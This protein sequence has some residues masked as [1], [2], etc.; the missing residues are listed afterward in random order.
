MLAEF[1]LEGHASLLPPDTQ[2]TI[3]LSYVRLREIVARADLLVNISG[4]L[5]DE[6]F[7]RIPVRAWLD[8]DP[9][10]NQ[11]WQ[12]QG[13][14][15]RMAGHT[16]FV[17]IG[18]AIG[19]PGCRV[20]TCGFSWIPTPQP[21]V[22]SQ[23]PVAE[24]LVYDAFTTV[25]NWR[26]YGPI[27]ADGVFYGQKAHS[28][29]QFFSLP[30]Q[31]G[32][33]FLLAMS[34]HPDEHADL[35]ALDR[36]GWRLIEPGRV[37]G[38][39]RAY[40]DF[41]RGSLAELGIAKSGYVAANCGW[42][43][44]RSLCYLASG[45][46]VV[47]QETGFSRFLPTGAGLLAFRT[48]DE[49]AE[50]V[51]CI[52][53]DYARHAR[54]ARGLAEEHF[55]SSRGTRAAPEPTGSGPMSGSPAGT[56][57]LTAALQ[58]A[59]APASPI[60]AIRRRPFD[61]RSS[62]PLE[63]IELSFADGRRQTLI[64]K[65]LA[66]DA[67]PE[68]RQIKP[69]FLF[70]PRREIDV[71]R[72]ILPP[73]RLDTARCY[74]AVSDRRRRRY[75]LFLEKVA[76]IEF[77]QAG[78][79]ETWCDAARWLARLHAHFAGADLAALTN[80]CHL[81]TLDA[82]LFRQFLQRACRFVSQSRE[83]AATTRLQRLADRYEPVLGALS[84]LPRTFIHGEFY[85][86]NVLVNPTAQP[87]RICP[88]D[89]E[90]AAIGP[91][92]VDLA[93]LVVGKW[94]APQQETIAMAY[95]A[96]LSPKHPLAGDSQEFPAGLNCCRRQLAVQWLGW[97][98]DWL[99][100][101]AHAPRLAGRGVPHGGRTGSVDLRSIPPVLGR[102]Q[103]KEMMRYVSNERRSGE[104]Q[105]IAE[106]RLHVSRA[107]RGDCHYWHPGRANCAG[108]ASGAGS[109]PQIPVCQQPQTMGLGCCAT[110]RGAPDLSHRW[111][112][113]AV[114]RRARTRL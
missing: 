43:S 47:A 39:P 10:F 107:S 46:P 19:Q 54:A 106:P 11:L 25:G 114:G 88:V 78:D 31:T 91:G 45:R 2:D 93:A 28:L 34:I 35:E 76:A 71:Y 42:F 17:T 87:L 8:L 7:R 14:D 68:T 113:V 74:G 6:A 80:D 52:R 13:V 90:M 59:P 89:W 41:I 53:S 15:M 58:E 112:G 100:P 3:G 111:L 63:E 67:S 57:D 32:E 16:H 49:A 24:Q 40:R 73:A 44:D 55:E 98:P 38:T 85:A 61:Y 1:G 56:A 37:A 108:G 62:F 21:I 103:K 66:W 22:L 4:M 5:T 26:S 81:L 33:Q 82:A 83:P 105:A 50:A 94:T 64:F 75:W 9:A 51:R 70:D 104:C 18:Q 29:R 23:W 30:G 96:A 48:L 95:H 109:G 27:T 110:S 97:S 84:T 36:N 72:Q 69:E 20:P 99:P 12:A 65:D 101:P 86:S 102:F 92:L 77:Y 60:A 79:L